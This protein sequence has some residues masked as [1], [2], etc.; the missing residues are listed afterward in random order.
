MSQYVNLL[1]NVTTVKLNN[2]FVKL[3]PT[4]SYSIKIVKQLCYISTLC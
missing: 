1:S 3:L 4:I 2:S